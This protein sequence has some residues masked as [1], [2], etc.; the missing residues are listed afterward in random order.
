M[1]ANNDTF[2][3]PIVWRRRVRASPA[4]FWYFFWTFYFQLISGLCE[5]LEEG[6][7]RVREGDRKTDFVWILSL[8]W[9]VATSSRFVRRLRE[10]TMVHA[11]WKHAI[12]CVG[13]PA[14]FVYGFQFVLCFAVRFSFSLGVLETQNTH[15]HTLHRHT[16]CYFMLDAWKRVRILCVCA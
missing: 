15:T 13:G 7:Q 8:R 14:C 16:E 10:R 9:T 1:L 5:S 4:V 6:R 3:S 2:K 11:D 12:L